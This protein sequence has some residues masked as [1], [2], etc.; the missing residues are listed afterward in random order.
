[1]KNDLVMSL[2]HAYYISLFVCQP[3]TLSLVSAVVTGHII[4]H[5]RPQQPISAPPVIQ[6]WVVSV[7][8]IFVQRQSSVL[9]A[10]YFKY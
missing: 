6:R 2:S 5:P 7:V 9:A 8:G 3:V 1:M 10:A 4:Q